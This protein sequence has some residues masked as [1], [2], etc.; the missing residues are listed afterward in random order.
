MQRYR[1][2]GMVK[3][4]CWLKN[5][6]ES[7]K[8]THYIELRLVRTTTITGAEQTI[9][10]LKPCTS[11]R[12]NLFRRDW[13]RLPEISE[14]GFITVETKCAP[15]AAKRGGFYFTLTPEAG[16]KSRPQLAKFIET[17]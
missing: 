13:R 17:H 6:D 8:H 15:A 7:T 14:G 4:H 16:L 12:L 10:K 1:I 9:S 11:I 3:S 2:T 5:F